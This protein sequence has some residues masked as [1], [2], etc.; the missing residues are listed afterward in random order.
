MVLEKTLESPLDCK[1]IQPVHSKGNQP[2]IFTGRTDAETEAPILQSPDVKSRHTGKDPDSRKEWGQ[3]ER[4]ATEDE[5]AGWHHGLNQHESE[6]TTEQ[7][8]TGKPGALQPLGLDTTQQQQHNINRVM[9]YRSQYVI[10][11]HWFFHS[12]Q[13]PWYLNCYVEQ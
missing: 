9:W 10:C 11:W 8:R 12:K 3:E 1:E 4:A 7:W 5:M 2:W 13:C 6:Q